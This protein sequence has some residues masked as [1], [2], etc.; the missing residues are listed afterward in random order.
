MVTLARTAALAALL[1]T[2]AAGPAAADTAADTAASP[3]AVSG[4][5]ARAGAPA[6]RAG[7]AFMSI[8]NNGTEPDRLVAAETPVA[9]KAELH[10][11]LMDNGVM[12]MRPVDAIEITPGEPAVL[13]PGGMHVML[14]G[15]K[16]PLTEGS[17]F[18][19]TLRFAKAGTLTVEVP[20]QSAASMGPGGHGAMPGSMH[21]QP[22]HQQPMQQH[23]H[24]A[25]PAKPAH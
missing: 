25:D 10:T 20:V 24:G 19:I 11:H 17:R 5:W 3:I 8:A 12:R 21:Q 2:V 16:Q 9:D 14:I 4:P 15:L 6:A 18:P 13:A 22:A 7:A 23:M 1:L